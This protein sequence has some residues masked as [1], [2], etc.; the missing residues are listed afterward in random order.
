MLQI[1]DIDHTLIL[2]YTGYVCGG[3]FKHF[4]KFFMMFCLAAYISSL[5]QLKVSFLQ[6]WLLY[7]QLLEMDI[8]HP[9]LGYD[10]VQVCIMSFMI[11][12]YSKKLYK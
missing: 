8:F 7:T 5:F 9:F 12:L 11:L 10:Q 1:T 4:L 3:F 6:E 2:S